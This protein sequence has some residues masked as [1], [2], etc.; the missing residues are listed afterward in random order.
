[1]TIADHTVCSSIFGLYTESRRTN[2]LATIVDEL[3]GTVTDG[4]V[5]KLYLSAACRKRRPP[6]GIERQVRRE[7]VSM[8]TPGGQVVH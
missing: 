2:G 3:S 7:Q 4:N 1:M 6:A 8:T 5:D